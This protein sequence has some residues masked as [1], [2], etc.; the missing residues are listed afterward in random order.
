M[1]SRNCLSVSQW[2]L[3]TT[4]PY[5]NG[6]IARP[7]PKTKAPALRKKRKRVLI[8]A[9]EAEPKTPV[10]SFSTPPIAGA[11][12]RAERE[13]GGALINIETNPQRTKSQTISASFQAVV[14][15]NAMK[16]V[17]SNQSFLSVERTN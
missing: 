3:P 11:V 10:N 2:N 13:R 14:T 7:L 1:A 12:R 8:V 17:H 5:K 9:A 4:P 6:T 16:R 15:A